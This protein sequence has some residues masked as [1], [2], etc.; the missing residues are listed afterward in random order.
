MATD[1]YYRVIEYGYSNFVEYHIVWEGS[2]EPK[3]R[4]AMFPY[5][6]EERAQRYCD[7]LNSPIKKEKDGVQEQSR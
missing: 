6:Q 1:G 5:D 3:Q 4:I 7:F 2:N